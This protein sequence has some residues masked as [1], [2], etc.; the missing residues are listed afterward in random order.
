MKKNM[1][2]ELVASLA[3]QKTNEEPETFLAWLQDKDAVSMVSFLETWAGGEEEEMAEV[4]AVAY[5]VSDAA[6]NWSEEDLNLFY[7]QLEAEKAHPSDILGGFVGYLHYHEDSPLFRWVRWQT[8]WEVMDATLE[9]HSFDW[10]AGYIAGSACYGAPGMNIV[11]RLVKEWFAYF[12][13]EGS[14]DYFVC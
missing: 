1:N 12:G 7:N 5:R 6:E 11:G 3:A 2:L 9:G 8:A 14:A 13:D 4:T 10:V